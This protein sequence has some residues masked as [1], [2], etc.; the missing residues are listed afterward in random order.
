MNTGSRLALILARALSRTYAPFREGGSTGD[1]TAAPS[2][3]DL[4][5]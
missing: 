3:S 2:Q 5:N 4:Q 1:E